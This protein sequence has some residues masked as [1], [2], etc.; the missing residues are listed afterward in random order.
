VV[1]TNTTNNNVTV[2]NFLTFIPLV[3]K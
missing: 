3:V 1:D 2:G